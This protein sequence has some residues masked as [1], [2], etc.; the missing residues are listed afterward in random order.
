ME[1]ALTEVPARELYE[2][3]G[4]QLMPINT[5]FE[6]AAMAAEQ[7]AALDAAETLLLIPDLLHYWLC[8]VRTSELTNAT[9]TQCFDPRAGTWAVDLLERLGIPSRL[10][11]EVVQAGTRLAR[12]SD[13]VAE[14]TGLVDA[15]VVAVATHDTGSA[16]AAVPFRQPGSVFISAGTWSLVGV[17][18]ERPLITDATFAA[19]LTNEGG[20]G[21]TYRL[22]RNV[23]G[24]WIVHECRRAWALEGREYSFDQLIALAKETPALRSLIEPNDPTFGDQGGDMPARVRAFCAHTG[25]PEPVEPGAVVRCILE[26]LALKHAQTIDVLA[27]VTGTA[28]AEIHLVGGGA[29]N[30][31]LCRWTAAAAG[32]PVLAGPEEATL[33]GNLLVQAMSLGEIASIQEGREV[34]RASF[35]P[36]IYEPQDPAIW[37]EARERFVQAVALPTLGVRA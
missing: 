26:S 9:T 7:D 34:V 5:V 12:L 1:S 6:L 32:I 10:L 29:R 21:S 20:I 3:T 19:N 8:G 17:E 11:P 27:S 36:T 22:L 15:V 33:L 24:L 25:Q 2:R 23:A 35:A 4:I 16:V 13:E 31:L 28:P 30:E 18:V 14:V 37:Q